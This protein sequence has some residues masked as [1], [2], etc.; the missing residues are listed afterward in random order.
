MDIH[1]LFAVYGIIPPLESTLD[2]GKQGQ[3]AV[4]LGETDT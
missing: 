2:Q 3:E 4:K 1:E